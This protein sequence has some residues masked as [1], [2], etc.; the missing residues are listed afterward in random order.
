VDIFF[1]M[2]IPPDGIAML[3]FSAMF[4][5]APACDDR[6]NFECILG[7]IAARLNRNRFW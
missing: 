2:A 6:H 1:G 4:Q 5:S 3:I 7:S